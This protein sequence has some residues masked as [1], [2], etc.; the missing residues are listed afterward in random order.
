M[1]LL[2]IFNINLFI[3]LEVNY[4]TYGIGF[5]IHPHE[6]ATGVHVFPILYPPPTFLPIPS[7]WVI[8]VHQPQASCIMHR[9]WTS[10]SFNIWNYSCF[11]AL[12]PN[13]RTLSHRVIVFYMLSRLVVTLLPRSKLP[14]I[15]WLQS[16]F[17]SDFGAQKNKLS[18]CFHYFPIYF[19]YSDGTRCHDLRFLN[20]EV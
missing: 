20:V 2:F 5:A 4:F 19:P 1:S 7:L 12:L 9:T 3:F 10:D 17:C 8:P 16:P 11:N 6:P 14:L 13:H 18:H 15:S